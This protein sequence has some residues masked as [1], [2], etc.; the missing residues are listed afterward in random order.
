MAATARP[1][2]PCGP[3]ARF[4]ADNLEVLAEVAQ[5]TETRYHS[6]CIVQLSGIVLS[7]AKRC[8]N[9]APRS[10]S[11]CH[12]SSR[13]CTP[14]I[15]TIAPSH[16]S[17]CVSSRY[18]PG[19]PLAVPASQIYARDYSFFCRLP[20]ASY[21]VLLIMLELAPHPIGLVFQVDLWIGAG[22]SGNG[23]HA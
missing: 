1:R 11:S 6:F 8:N 4:C 23:I 12:V 13:L 3:H 18:C 19:I 20:G 7:H 22:L 2:D 17:C 16:S 15:P 10:F 5:S 14:R 21:A 9:P